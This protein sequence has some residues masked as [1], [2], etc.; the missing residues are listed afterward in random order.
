MAQGLFENY[1]EEIAARVNALLG[2]GKRPVVIGM[3]GMAASGKTTLAALLAERLDAAVIHMDD[4][5]L[6]QGF[7][8]PERLRS[9]GGN[10]YYERFNQEVAPYLRSGELFAYRV[11]DAHKH[12]YV[13]VRDVWPK[14]VII[15]EGCYCMHPE[16]GDIYDLRLFVEI[17]PYEQE[18]RIAATR[19]ARAEMFK[20]MWIPMENRYHKHF[21]IREQCHMVISSGAPQ[22]APPLEIERKWLIRMPDLAVLREKAV[23]VIDMEQVYLKGAAP[24]VS[25][26]VRKSVEGDKITYHRNE[27]QKL[28]ATVRIEREEEINGKHYNI[29]LG[30]ADPALRKIQKTRYCVPIAGGL[31]AEIDIFPFWGDRAFCEVELPYEDTPVTLPQWLEIVR[32]VSD[33]KRYTNLALAR[34]IP[35]EEIV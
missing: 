35:T 20:A 10:V 24:G 25:M 26:R 34:E 15:V 7:R 23:R 19:P 11:F 30:F 32:E 12:E 13:D 1:I 3:D 21:R 16:I 6:P 27:K 22:P 31:T 33:D 8:T 17:S 9:P 18:Q 2:D 28:S 29:L 4:F 5:F 14:P